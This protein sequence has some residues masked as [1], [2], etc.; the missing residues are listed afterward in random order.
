MVAMTIMAS[1]LPYADARKNPSKI[2]KD[3]QI[4]K[5]A[6]RVKRVR[7]AAERPRS[8]AHRRGLAGGRYRR[9]R[10]FG[11]RGSLVALAPRLIVTA[12]LRGD[13]W[14]RPAFGR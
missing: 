12:S 8:L 6:Q 5:S 14:A 3:F 13:R 4:V 2:F 7:T 11:S 10:A 1:T 9:P